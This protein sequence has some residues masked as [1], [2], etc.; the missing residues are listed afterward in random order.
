MLSLL[1]LFFSQRNYLISDKKKE[2]YNLN[3][4]KTTTRINNLILQ[5][6]CDSSTTLVTPHRCTQGGG[7]KG[8]GG[9]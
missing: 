6:K 5:L 3:K 8:G 4:E 7:G 9:V 1:T 2:K